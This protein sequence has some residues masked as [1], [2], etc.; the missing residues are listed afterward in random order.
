MNAQIKFLRESLPREWDGDPRAQAWVAIIVYGAATAGL[1]ELFPESPDP[2]DLAGPDAWVLL[3]SLKNGVLH[4]MSSSLAKALSL[5]ASCIVVDRIIVGGRAPTPQGL[6]NLEAAWREP[7]IEELRVLSYAEWRSLRAERVRLRERP[8]DSRSVYQNPVDIGLEF[9]PAELAAIRKQEEAQAR[10]FNRCELEL[11]AQTWS[12]HCKHKIFA[13]RIRC[14]DTRQSLTDGL[15]KTHLRAPTMEIMAERPGTFLSVFH[16]N[17]GVVALVNGE[18]Q[19]TEWSLCMKMETHNSPSAISPYGGASTGIVGVH[20]DILGTGLGAMPVAS[21]DVLCFESPQHLDGRPEGALPPDL[22]RRG[23]IRG[24][25]DGGNQSGIPTVQGSVVFDPSYAAKPLVYAG[26]LGILRKEHVDKKP[27][28]GDRLYCVGGAVGP[29]GLRGA[30]MSS[31][32][33]RQE[34]FSGSAVQVAQPFVQ[35]C[36]TDFLLDA[37]DKGLISCSTD[38][39]AGGLA[40]SVGEMSQST[41]GARVE[42]G[43]LRLKF[44][45]LHGWERLLS[46]SQERMTVATRD[47]EAFEE[48]ARFWNV[49]F[50]PLGELTDSGRFEVCYQGQKLSDMELSFLH[51]ACP[52]MDLEST[53]TAVRETRALETGRASRKKAV[54]PAR[55]ALFLKL[56]ESPHLASREGVVRRFDHEVQGRTLRKPFAGLTQESPQDAALLELAEA[57]PGVH[58]VLAHGLA[59]WRDEIHENVLSG[60]D[61]AL[62]S[63]VLGGARLESCGLLD[64]FSWPDPIPSSKAP[65][66]ERRLWRL[67]RSCELLSQ[68]ARTFRIPFISGK[69]SM[70]NNTGA[71]ECRETLVLSIAGSSGPGL[72][73]PAG[74]FTRANDVVF[75][76][77]ML[78]STLRDSVVERVLGVDT[79]APGLLKAHDVAGI[80]AEC[81]DLLRKLK[82]RYEAFSKAVHAGLVRAAKDVS[83]GG[84]L[85]ACFEMTLGRRLGLQFESDLVDPAACFAEGL[86]G[87]VFT[88]DVHRIADVEALLPDARRLGVV[89]RPFVLRFGADHQVDLKPFEDAYLKLTREGFWS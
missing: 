63:A 83:E 38:N 84:L 30:V 35:R 76:M 48:L 55:D 85:T 17:A 19:P 67:V 77:P 58:A 44:E 69:D 42:V 65:N 61:E 49:D 7:A 87:L 1:A 60:F 39:G 46:E 24:I 28:K 64:N 72:N 23:V 47:P 11:I 89:M 74:F 53:W 29:D 25:E 6:K 86:G 31:R 45:G 2:E 15:F 18:G 8:D 34:D 80:D 54:L 22:I 26:T 10:R 5:E 57:G 51:D 32:D 37:R 20:R 81:G 56:L 62:R 78:R 41:G 88:C 79:G 4:P 40:S 70:K 73:V 27:K 82:Q 66:A 3:R 33:L 50:D 16:D 75:H 9:S 52:R 71:F 36:V 14:P 21:W 13:A 68:A 43:G 59:P 12:E